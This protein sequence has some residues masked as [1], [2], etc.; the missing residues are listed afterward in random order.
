VAG[1]WQLNGVATLNTTASP[2]NLELTPATNWLVGSAF[3]PTPVPGV[4]VSATFDAFL[5][6]SSGSGADGMTFTLADASV[7]Q[8]TALGNNGGGEGFSGITG[9]AVSLD[10]WMNTADP[11][12]N[13][14]G[15]ATTNTSQQQLNYVAT[16]TSIP[17]LRNA[18]HNF[19]VTTSSTGITVLMDGTQVLNYATTLPP[20]VLIGF[21]AATGGFNDVHEVQNVSI[22]TGTPPAVPAVT[23]LSP[24][25]G[26][27]TGGTSV[28]IT[29]TNLTGATAVDFGAAPATSFTVNSA[30]SI[31]ASAPASTAGTFDVTVTTPGGTSLTTSND[32][33]TYT[34]PPPPAVSSVSPTSGPTAGGNTVT[35]SG[36]GFTGTTAV[37]FGTTAA[38]T[39]TVNNSTSITATAP[40]GTAGAVD[41]TVTT[42]NGTSATSAAD[43]YTYNAAPPPPPTVTGVSPATDP[44]G[45]SITVTGTNFTGATAVN[46]GTANP[47][48]FTVN[49]STTITA[50]A[51]AGSGTV[52]VT[53]TTPIATSATSPVDQFTYGAG[54]PPYVIPSPVGGAGSTTAKPR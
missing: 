1:G 32:Q 10:T 36:T 39:L 2:P 53:V 54:P 24:T 20:F 51:P 12:N 23:S 3:Y 11:S 27:T 17:A 19:V 43:Q 42:A 5:G 29:G 30:T 33:Y 22:T 9:I 47:A 13:F 7:T 37:N 16:N 4:G 49:N 46:F 50:T 34:A 41:V 45:S 25:S 52:D 48:T 38:T 44:A 31:T 18:V 14:V 35:I 28:T 26:P 8:P 21:T 15:I 6:S 40:A